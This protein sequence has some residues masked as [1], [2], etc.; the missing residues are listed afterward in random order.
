MADES[1]HA[2]WMPEGFLGGPVHG[3]KTDSLKREVASL[4]LTHGVAAS[5][6]FV[7][8]EAVHLASYS[9]VQK[10]V[11]S[12]LATVCID[13]A[14]LEGARNDAGGEEVAARGGLGR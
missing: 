9:S 13:D 6:A 4:L 14:C 3:C 10:E 11:Q 1:D 2:V 8:H 12:S 7:L 5:I